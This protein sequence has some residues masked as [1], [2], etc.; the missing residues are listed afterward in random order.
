MSKRAAAIKAAYDKGYRV[1]EGGQ[2]TSPKGKTL[3]L[4]TPKHGRQYLRFTI[5]YEGGPICLDVHR[6]AGYQKFGDAIFEPGQQVRHLNDVGT[7]NR[8][9]NIGLG[10]ASQN[11]MDMPENKRLSRSSI[12]GY[13]GGRAN[14]VFTREEIHQILN[15]L[16]K[17]ES[18]L[19]VA[20]SVGV[21]RRTIN[22]IARGKSYSEWY[23]EY[24]SA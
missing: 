21:G 7:D 12:G 5:Y 18:Q 19:E 23:D 6:L 16:D 11:A 9:E 22:N 13:L 2:V 14:R 15:R 24:Q 10:N 1:T 20:D 3:S 4:Y 17:G 8:L